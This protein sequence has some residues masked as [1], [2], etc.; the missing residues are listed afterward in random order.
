MIQPSFVY[1]KI[2]SN[3][4]TTKVKR[5][6][7]KLGRDEL[8]TELFLPNLGQPWRDHNTA[9]YNTQRTS[10]HIIQTWSVALVLRILRS[11]LTETNVNPS[12]SSIASYFTTLYPEVIDPLF[13][14]RQDQEPPFPISRCVNPSTFQ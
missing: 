1:Q 12:P 10:E 5:Q 11:T 7:G 3:S 8:R 9:E 14:K 13:L 2:C 4:E 6:W